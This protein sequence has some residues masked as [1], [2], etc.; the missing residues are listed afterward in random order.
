MGSRVSVHVYRG[1]ERIT[2]PREVTATIL[3]AL[4][5]RSARIE[6]SK[7]A[8]L[9]GMRRLDTRRCSPG[10]ARDRARELLEFWAQG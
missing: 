6:I 5:G 8:A 2:G 1:I 4:S 3:Y 7:P 9:G 10:R